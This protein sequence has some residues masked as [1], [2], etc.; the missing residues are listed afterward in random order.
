MNL[1]SFELEWQAMDN[2]QTISQEVKRLQFRIKGILP[3]AYHSC[4]DTVSPTSMGSA[5]LKYSADG[6]VAWDEI[7]TS[8]AILHWQAAR[9]TRGNYFRP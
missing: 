3:L 2:K 5:G 8:F 1:Q 6:K 7:W 9:P 4:M